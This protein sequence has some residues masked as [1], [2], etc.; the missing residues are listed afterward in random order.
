MVQHFARTEPERGSDLPEPF[1]TRNRIFL[2]TPSRLK[3]T[4]MVILTSRSSRFAMVTLTFGILKTFFDLSCPEVRIPHTLLSDKAYLSN[5]AR[6]SVN[7]YYELV[8][9]WVFTYKGSKHSVPSTQT[10]L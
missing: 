5:Q 4:L 7:A 10:G 1:R 6:G 9:D 2:A 3:H 8:G